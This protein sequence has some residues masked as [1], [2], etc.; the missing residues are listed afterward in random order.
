MQDRDEPPD[1]AISIGEWV[2]RLELI[3]SGGDADDGVQIVVIVDPCLPR[4]QPSAR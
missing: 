2:Q 4:G 3:V 1:S